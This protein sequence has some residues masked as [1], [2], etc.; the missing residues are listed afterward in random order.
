MELILKE[1]KESFPEEKD[2]MFVVGGCVRDHLLGV[3]SKDIDVLAR[4]KPEYLLNKGAKY[5]D[6]SSSFPVFLYRHPVLGQ[7]EIALPRTEKK[8]GTGHK[9]FDVYFDENL[10]IEIDLSRRDITINS[11]AMSLEGELIDPFN[12]Y[13][14][15]KTKVL[16]HTSNAFI[17]DSLR[18]YR[19]CRFACKGF[20]IDWK[21]LV[22]MGTMDTSD[23]PVERI[24]NEM[25][26]A[27]KEDHPDLFFRKIIESGIGE[28]VFKPVH[29]MLHIPSG[30]I[31]YH[32]EGSVFAHSILT[33]DRVA[34]VNKN[35]I[36]R[37]AAFFH[38]IGNTLTPSETW[39]SHHGHDQLGEE[40]LGTYLESLKMS[41]HNK[42]II[43]GVCKEHMKAPFMASNCAISMKTSKWLKLAKNAHD[44]NYT[45]ALIDTV[46]ADSNELYDISKEMELATR[47]ANMKITELGLSKEYLE[48][49]SGDAISQVILQRR[50]ELLNK[51]RLIVNYL[52]NTDNT[53]SGVTVSERE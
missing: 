49:R 6:P 19:V 16:R 27:F 45:Q 12:G 40:F 44:G 13:Y 25:E 43:I 38:D 41:T 53:I 31:E 5:I 15:I 52:Q 3:E 37:L 46:F 20:T 35:A 48:D 2:N 28:D 18:A 26:K 34:K 17:D 14:D 4:V 30:P 21:T 51:Y 24:T 29:D 50:V 42:R 7:I 23:L 32:P 8:S 9:G 36:D 10:P 11:M 1:L 47:V 39:P 33:L 22:L